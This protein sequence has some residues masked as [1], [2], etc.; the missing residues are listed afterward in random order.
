MRRQAATLCGAAAWR[1]GIEHLFPDAAPQSWVACTG[2]TSVRSNIDD[3]R[4][5]VHGHEDP[6][7]RQV[8]ID[9]HGILMR[10]PTTH[11]HNHMAKQNHL[12][13]GEFQRI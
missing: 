9:T 6:S 10:Q 2:I 13:A 12:I 3:K 11:T 4:D 7:F 1:P 5:K 8:M